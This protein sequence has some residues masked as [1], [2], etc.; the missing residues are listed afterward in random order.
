MQLLA[1]QMD[2]AGYVQLV[3]IA[4]KGRGQN[5]DELHLHFVVTL[6]CTCFVALQHLKNQPLLR[7]MT[8][9]AEK[10]ATP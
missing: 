5:S 9:A 3:C 7:I 2:G 4:M 8:S 10:L 1:V 6:T